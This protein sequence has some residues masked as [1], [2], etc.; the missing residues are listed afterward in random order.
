M[1]FDQVVMKL[2]GLLGHMYL[3]CDQYVQYL[4]TG[5]NPSVLNRHNWGYILRGTGFPY[6]SPR[7]SQTMVLHFPLRV[8]PGLQF[9]ILYK[10]LS[11][12]P[13]GENLLPTHG[14]ATTRYLPM[15]M[16]MPSP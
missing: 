1:W 6:H 7:L 5:V 11:R 15:H 14:L 10:K 12:N 4:F 13:S 8:P 2:L 16:S 9:T 3:A